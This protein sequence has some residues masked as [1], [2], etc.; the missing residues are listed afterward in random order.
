MTTTPMKEACIAA[1]ELYSGLR[2]AGF[3]RS[4]AIE[5]VARF[6]ATAAGEQQGG[7]HD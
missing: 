5:L 7:T 4:E 3:A 1:H 2:E 6:I